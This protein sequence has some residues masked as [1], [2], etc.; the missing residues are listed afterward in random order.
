MTTA[1]PTAGTAAVGAVLFTLFALAYAWAPPS[2][3]RQH[4]DSLEYAHACE[5]RVIQATMWGNHPLGHLLHCGVFKAARRLGYSGRAL[6]VLQVV[7]AVIGAAAV[8]ALFT[9]MTRVIGASRL[10]AV[11][12]AVVLGGAYGFWRHAG[13]GDI[14]GLSML[15]L[16]VAWGLIV[17]ALERPSHARGARAG[18]AFGVAALAH[19]LGGLVLVVGML[20]LL[21]LLGRRWARPALATFV[22]TAAAT[23]VIGYV[24]AGV[25]RYHNRLLPRAILAWIVG[26][27]SDPTYGRA[28]TLDRVSLAIRGLSA[29]LVRD[30]EFASLTVVVAAAAGAALLV[31]SAVGIPRL[32][33]RLRTIALACALQCLA[34]WPLVTWWEPHHVGK[35]WLLTLP[36]LVMWGDLALVGVAQGARA[37]MWTRVLRDLPLLAG[38]LVLLNTASVMAV[39]RRSDP[40]WERALTGWVTHSA[41]DDVLIENGGLTAHLRFWGERPGTVNLYRIIQATG[42]DPDRF[43]KLRALIDDTTRNGHAVLFDPGL[44]TYLTDDRLGVIGTTRREVEAFLD[45]YPREGPLFTY[46]ESSTAPV[47]SVYRLRPEPK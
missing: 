44:S 19:Q 4:W 18:I 25:F 31:V 35:F 47:R 15:T 41:A 36:A 20:G 43:V 14:Y 8:A 24:A 32:F 45:R 2:L 30:A 1:H 42:A 12:G 38:M 23:T 11:S 3:E 7:S 5:V 9:G 46:Q 16:I 17:A 33:P 22:V 13:M 29:T 34:I 28:L 27:G 26:Y 10:R 6:P 37:T 21:P 40:A 39:Y